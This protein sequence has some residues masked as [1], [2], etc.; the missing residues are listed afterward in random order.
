[1]VRIIEKRNLWLSISAGMVVVGLVALALWQLR[2]G[3]DFTGG[4]LLEI[5]YVAARVAPDVLHTHLNSAGIKEGEIK[6]IGE[7]GV[8]LR[9]KTI[10][11]DTHQKLVAE[12]KK[13][14]GKLVERAFESIGPVI[15]HELKTKSLWALAI[16]LVMIFVYIAFVFRKVS[17]P[18]ASWKYGVAAIIALLHDLLFVLG[19]FAFLGKVAGVEITSS[20]IPA[21][22]TILGFSVHDTIVVFDRIRENILKHKGVFHEIVNKSLNET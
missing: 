5:E 11:E 15:G 8:I 6:T 21:F 10:D 17:H 13:D 16:A 22:L 3:I 7:K 18:V 14:D 9:F 4:S 1:M 19:I 12:L 20:F 2:L